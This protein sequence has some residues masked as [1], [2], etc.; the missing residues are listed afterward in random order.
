LDSR[1][2]AG[3]SDDVSLV[4]ALR[5]D[6]SAGAGI[7]RSGAEFSTAPGMASPGIRGGRAL[8]V[9][10]AEPHQPSVHVIRILIGITLGY[11]AWI[12]WP[13]TAAIAYLVIAVIAL[14]TGLVG[15]C[16]AYAICGISTAKKKTAA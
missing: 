5:T 6:P 15:W 16:A 8:A 13:G 12:S 2:K 11:A 3:A 1:R 9:R 4:S 14:A 7:F 10:D